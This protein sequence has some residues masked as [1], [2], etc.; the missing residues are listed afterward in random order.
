[1][2]V[3]ILDCGLDSVTD[4]S[5]LPGSKLPLLFSIEAGWEGGWHMSQRHQEEPTCSLYRPVLLAVLHLEQTEQLEPE[6]VI[7]F[8]VCLCV[9]SEAAC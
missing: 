6:I 2:S 7:L 8:L 1:M 3:A 9:Y 4:I 5:P